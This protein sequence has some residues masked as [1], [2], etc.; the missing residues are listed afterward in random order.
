[1]KKSLLCHNGVSVV[2]WVK[3]TIIT[4]RQRHTHKNTPYSYDLYVTQSHAALHPVHSGS[5]RAAVKPFHGCLMVMGTASPFSSLNRRET[6][7]L[8][9]VGGASREDERRQ[10]RGGERKANEREGTHFTT[11]SCLCSKNSSRNSSSLAIKRSLP[12]FQ[13]KQV[14]V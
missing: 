6:H 10:D 5:P 13:V 7:T 14:V 1:M 9:R 4:A 12:A 8:E 11:G 3:R 2:H